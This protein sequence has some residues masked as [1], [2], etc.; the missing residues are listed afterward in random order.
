VSI[1]AEVGQR[2][3]KV[4]VE[5]NGIGIAPADS[6]RIFGIFERLNSAAAYEGTGIGL[7][8][9]RRAAEKMNAATGVESELGVGSRFWIELDQA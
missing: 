1:R 7:S 4:W 3:V 2:R 5:D 9:V 8:I 6:A